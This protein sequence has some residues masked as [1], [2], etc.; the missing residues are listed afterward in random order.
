MARVLTAAALLAI[1]HLAIF[2]LQDRLFT[3]FVL[4]L[5]EVAAI[6]FALLASRLGGKRAVWS[7]PV[8]VPIALALLLPGQFASSMDPDV[9][10]LLVG[11]LGSIVV[12]LVA[13]FSRSS[14]EETVSSAGL[15][16][17]GILYFAVP[18]AAI[19]RLQSHDVW[20]V[21]LTLVIV[22]AGD[23][24][25]FYIG[26]RF[27]RHKLA[28]VVSPNKSWEGAAAS[29]VASVLAGAAWSMLRLGSVEATF[30]AV[31]VLTSVAAQTGD[32][33]ESTLKRTVGVKDSSRL[34][35]GHGGMLDRLDSLLFAAP[36]LALGLAAIGWDLL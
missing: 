28:P 35:P 3:L 26:T 11:L 8:L 33:V 15:A 30:L 16:S 20:L 6:E 10:L 14:L 17:F 1:A 27:G 9:R 24:A 21:I 32:L 13:L 19:V 25:A 31:V 4:V 34:L 5:V 29:L 18:A 36:T 12:A 23:T 7:V 2:R 22:A